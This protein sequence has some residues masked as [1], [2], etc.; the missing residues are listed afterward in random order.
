MKYWG[1]ALGNYV[2]TNYSINDIKTEV[3]DF[4]DVC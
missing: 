1:D 3:R 2:N 4:T